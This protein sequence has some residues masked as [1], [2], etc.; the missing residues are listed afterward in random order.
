MT[1]AV[2]SFIKMEFMKRDQ[3][4][5]QQQN[6]GVD[7]RI[8]PWVDIHTR[9]FYYQGWRDGYHNTPKDYRYDKNPSYNRG[10]AAGCEDRPWT[11][12]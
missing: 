2:G 3:I 11:A 8:G 5:Q 6:D 1:I 10:Y 9:G 12:P 7:I 4:Q